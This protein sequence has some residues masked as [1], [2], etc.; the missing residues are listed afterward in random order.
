[1]PS[2]CPYHSAHPCRNKLFCRHYALASRL[3][4]HP[5]RPRKRVKPACYGS[6]TLNKPWIGPLPPARRRS[7]TMI[8]DSRRN[9]QPTD[10]LT[11]YIVHEHR[12]LARQEFILPKP[13]MLIKAYSGPANRFHSESHLYS[14]G[15]IEPRRMPQIKVSAARIMLAPLWCRIV[16]KRDKPIIL[17]LGKSFY[18]LRQLL[19]AVIHII[20]AEKGK[21][22]RSMF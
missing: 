12:I 22:C 3:G 17:M 10:S 21:R 9:M 18:Y 2:A 16:A 8:A 4:N 19:L 14:S 5:E 6:L 20:I 1:M 15:I 11:Q 7:S 13:E